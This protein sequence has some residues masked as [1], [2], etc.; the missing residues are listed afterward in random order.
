MTLF[1]FEKSLVPYHHKGTK[2]IGQQSAT[3]HSIFFV[4]FITLGH[5]SC[6]LYNLVFIVKCSL[7]LNFF[8]GTWMRSKTE[9]MISN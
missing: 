6:Y 7:L 5:K 2:I 4:Y 3:Y 1:S 9:G 8:L